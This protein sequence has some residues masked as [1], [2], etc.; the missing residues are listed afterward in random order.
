MNSNNKCPVCGNPAKYNYFGVR[1]CRKH[2]IEGTG[3]EPE[4]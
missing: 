3:V 4:L 2:W 1:V